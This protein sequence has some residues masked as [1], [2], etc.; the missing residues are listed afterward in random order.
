MAFSKDTT[1]VILSGFAR[2]IRG[3]FNH[4]KDNIIFVIIDPDPNPKLLFDVSIEA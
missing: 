1:L 4:A 2:M 3:F